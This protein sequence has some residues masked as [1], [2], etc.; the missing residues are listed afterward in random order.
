M[1][2]RFG[3]LLL[4]LLLFAVGLYWENKQDSPELSQSQLHAKVLDYIAKQDLNQ[5]LLV[6][7]T[8]PTKESSWDA[9]NTYPKSQVFA[10]FVYKD[11][12]AVYW[13]TDKISFT[14]FT[15]GKF[16]EMRFLDLPDGLYR[17]CSRL[18]SLGYAHYALLKLMHRYP[19]NLRSIARNKAVK[20]LGVSDEIELRASPTEGFFEIKSPDNEWVLYAKIIK[21]HAKGSVSSRFYLLGLLGL[22]LVALQLLYYRG[23]AVLSLR[24]GLMFCLLVSVVVLRILYEKGFFLGFLADHLLFSPELYASSIWADS[25]AEQGM[26]LLL[27]ALLLGFLHTL[28]LSK[29]NRFASLRLVLFV[30]LSGCFNYWLLVELR[31]LIMDSNIHFDPMVVGELDFYT[32]MGCLLLVFYVALFLIYIRL[33]AKYFFPL[34]IPLNRLLALSAVLFF[35]L[36]VLFIPLAN[37]QSA[38]F[39]MLLAWTLLGTSTVYY[40]QQLDKKHSDWSRILLLLFIAGF[41]ATQLNEL[42][43]KKEQE[44]RRLFAH[45]ML[46]ERDLELE[47]KLLEAEEKLTNNRVFESCIY[48]DSAFNKTEFEEILK[49]DYL[50]DFLSEFEISIE[51]ISG[52]SAFWTPITKYNYDR[53][54]QLFLESG[55]DNISTRFQKLDESSGVSGYL[56]AHITG[57]YRSPDFRAVFILLR[58]K[59]KSS[60]KVISE[61]TGQQGRLAQNPYGYYFALYLNNELRRVSPDFSFER[62]NQQYRPGQSEKF[63][64][65]EGI[66]YFIYNPEKGKLL[67]LAKK[68]R[69]LS[70]SFTVA[71]ALLMLFFFAWFGYLIL[72]FLVRIFKLNL[73]RKRHQGVA[74][75]PY[76]P[77]LR[78]VLLQNKIRAALFFELVISFFVG[79]FLVANYVS[80]NYNE[81]QQVQILEKMRGISAELEK[82]SLVDLGTI[83]GPKKE[84]LIR[85]SESY[86]IDINLFDLNGNLWM[87][88][89]SELFASSMLSP[90]MHPEAYSKLNNGALFSFNQ[91]EKLFRYTYHSYYQSLFDQDQTL[92]GYIHLPFF[93]RQKEA[94]RE[95]TSLILNLLNVFV[96]FLFVTGLVSVVLTKFITRPLAIVDTSL[97]KLRIDGKNEPIQWHS[98]DEIGQLVSTYNKVL[99]ELTESINRL[100]AGERE[101]AWREMAKQVAHEIKNPLTPMR[102]SVQH[103]QRTTMGL[104]HDTK[105]R[106]DKVCKLL[107]EQMDMMSKMAEEF[108]NFAKMPVASPEKVS[109]NQLL[110]DT[111]LLFD[112]EQNLQLILKEE[113][114]ELLV[115][116]DA[117]QLK[118]V[119]VNLIKNAHQAQKEGEP[120]RVEIKVYQIGK[121]VVLSFADNGVGI[122]DDIKPKLFRPNFST[123]NSGMG[124]GLAISKKIIELAEGS[125]F[126]ESEINKGTVFV[127]KLPLV[128]M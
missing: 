26:N 38:S 40:I 79:T 25:F 5:R 89:N 35:V 56:S 64:E 47:R 34:A 50:L 55:T 45:K 28:P 42:L 96:L 71:A 111:L 8:Y 90:F 95:L 120:V 104:E 87:S 81:A 110:K 122:A 99:D 128:N 22:F 125:I 44:F 53:F 23:R 127:I 63:E 114:P 39:S 43:E 10:Y 117:D 12:H 48:E 62:F 11:N 31:N 9:P 101:S 80:A 1:L 118:R 58:Q 27:F 32:L 46:Y 65:K 49:Y 109:V 106:I 112:K 20:E 74:F 16:V 30:V 78:H 91:N 113:S 94:K 85:L 100:A 88:S 66:S 54:Y 59:V 51:V 68:K 121:E 70:Q 86:A 69:S 105:E 17:V 19:Y 2:K 36:G 102:L 57:T 97:R 13:N 52:E 98:R 4:S 18:D 115:Y 93:A 123:K 124:L 77:S 6:S 41:F 75:V 37:E 61:F 116:V 60:R 15:T 3:I 103:L 33:F 92:V 7:H 67:V 14:P 76:L 29:W 84:F 82:S 107:I 119:F 24:T 72:R 83:N 73:K 126:F 108:S 21:T